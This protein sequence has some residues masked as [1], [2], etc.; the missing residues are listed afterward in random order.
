MMME[1]NLGS[2]MDSEMETSLETVMMKV[3]NSDLKKPRLMGS[4]MGSG[5][6]LSLETVMMKETEK[7][8]KI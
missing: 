3:I 5:M 8:I 6:G 1:I 4:G 7:V 2:G